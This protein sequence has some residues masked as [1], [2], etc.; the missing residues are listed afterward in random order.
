MKLAQQRKDF[1][2][3]TLMSEDSQNLSEGI[4]A[5]SILEKYDRSKIL[6]VY[7]SRIDGRQ[8]EFVPAGEED[9]YEIE[10]NVIKG[11]LL[12]QHPQDTLLHKVFRIMN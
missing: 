4:M 9:I 11:F 8:P 2:E 10:L 7:F 5:R 6:E 1:M 3:T 12:G